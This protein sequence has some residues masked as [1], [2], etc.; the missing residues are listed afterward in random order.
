MSHSPADGVVDA[1]SRVHGVGNLFVAGSSVFPT[2]G[3][4][5][6]TMM[7]IAL[8]LR[9]ADHLAGLQQG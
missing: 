4:S 6:P 3:Y 5:G 7:V 1:N 9:L 2:A 8:S